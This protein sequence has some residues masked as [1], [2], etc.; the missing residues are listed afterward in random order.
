M[1]QERERAEKEARQQ[2]ERDR[3]DYRQL[4]YWFDFLV[5]A[6]PLA[7]N[8]YPPKGQ[9]ENLTSRWQAG[10]RSPLNAKN[11]AGL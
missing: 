8:Y 4:K 6:D 2:A 11:Q 3:Q 1:I 7:D 10:G 5:K 9:S